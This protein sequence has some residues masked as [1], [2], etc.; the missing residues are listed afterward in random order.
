[1]VYEHLYTSTALYRLRNGDS[2]PIRT[3]IWFVNLQCFPQMQHFVVVQ[4]P[5]AVAIQITIIVSHLGFQCETPAAVL[6]TQQFLYKLHKNTVCVF[7]PDLPQQNSQW[8]SSSPLTEVRNVGCVW[9]NQA[10]WFR[11]S[12]P[13][14]LVVADSGGRWRWLV[15]FARRFHYLYQ[16]YTALF[17]KIIHKTIT[18]NKWIGCTYHL[19]QLFCL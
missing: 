18:I 10:V 7:I 11:W 8:I 13:L 3:T 19:F 17:V 4:L 15:W 1:V 9:V 2:G 14:W 12:W 6:N 16:N 5:S